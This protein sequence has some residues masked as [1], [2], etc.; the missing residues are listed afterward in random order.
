MILPPGTLSTIW[1]RFQFSQLERDASGIYWV[2]ARNAS[3][4]P[5][6]HKAAPT[7]DINTHTHTHTHTH[8]GKT[9]WPKKESKIE[10]M[11]FPGGTVD[12]DPER[13]HMPRSN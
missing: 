9:V 7:P 11:D 2:E 12:K 13:F 8:R 4:Q 6:M 1:R 10:W 3:K 5:T